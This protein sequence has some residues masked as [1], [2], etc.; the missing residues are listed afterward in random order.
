MILADFICPIHGRFEAMVDPDAEFAPC[1]APYEPVTVGLPKFLACGEPSPWSPSPIAVHTAFV[2]SATRGKS[3]P[4]PHKLATDTRAL[5]EG[6]SYSE[7]RAQRKK[8]WRDHDYR[9]RKERG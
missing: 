1:P 6:Q 3:D 9:V 2:V 7:W 8:L 4:P 5:G